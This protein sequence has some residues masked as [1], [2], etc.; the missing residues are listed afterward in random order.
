MKSI[1]QKG[2]LNIFR[3]RLNYFLATIFFLE[4]KRKKAK[5]D[6]LIG[7]AQIKYHDKPVKL[8]RF[9]GGA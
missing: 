6:I 3:G 8:F 1:K 4:E 9:I 5:K 7:R 2:Y